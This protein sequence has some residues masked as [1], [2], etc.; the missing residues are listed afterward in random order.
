MPKRTPL[1]QELYK[2]IKK[3]ADKLF[4]EKTSAYKSMWIVRKYIKE[5]GTYEAGPI[6]KIKKNSG[7]ERWLKEKWVDISKYDKKTK[8]YAPCGRKKLSEPFPICRPSIR[9]TKETPKTV[10]E[11]TKK[12]IK[13]AIVLKRKFNGKVRL[14]F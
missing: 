5:G 14:A 6:E 7:L 2:K 3:D 4:K 8:T 10:Q 1:N 9:I 11:L 13:D 12:Q